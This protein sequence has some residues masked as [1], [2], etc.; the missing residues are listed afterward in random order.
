MQLDI[1][2]LGELAPLYGIRIVT[3]IA[4]FLIGKW[5][6]KKVVN[7]IKHMMEKAKV[8]KTLVSFFGNVMYAVALAFV[9]IAALSQLGIE[10][11]SLAAIMAAAGL[12]VGMALKD[13]LGNLASGVMIILFRPFKIGDF[14]EAGGT[15]GIVEEITIFTT[16]MKTPDNKAVI[17]PNGAI[18]SGNITNFSA[19]DTRRI[20]MVIGVS[21]GDDLAKVKKVLTKILEKDDRVLKDP[22][23]FIGVMALADSSVNFAVRPWVKSADYWTTMTDLQEI[24]KVTF[25]KEGISIPFPQSEMRIVSGDVKKM[26]A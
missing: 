8:D 9:V 6:V 17:V 22:E 20:D 25:D 4:I 5:I 7:V 3:A 21:Y 10:T 26:A 19:K 24:I 12:A 13:S 14:I 16:M 1:N 15:S 2:S 11:T 18:T 23:P